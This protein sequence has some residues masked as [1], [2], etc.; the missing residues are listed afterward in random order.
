M[1][2]YKRTVAKNQYFSFVWRR[3][4]LSISFN[5]ITLLH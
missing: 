2:M 1:Q 5:T 4:F 3:P